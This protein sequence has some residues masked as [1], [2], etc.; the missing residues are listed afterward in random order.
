LSVGVAGGRSSQIIMAASLS[1][2][3]AR[4]LARR[5]EASA[6][7]DRRK[8]GLDSCLKALKK[9]PLARK[10]EGLCACVRECS[11]AWLLAL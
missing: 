2:A 3:L 11:A 4:L 10:E 7:V 9:L 6:T 1:V 5:D 8:V